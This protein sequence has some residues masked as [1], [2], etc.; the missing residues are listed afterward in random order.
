[1]TTREEKLERVNCPVCGREISLFALPEHVKACRK[2]CAA[3]GL[4]FCRTHL[5]AHARTPLCD[6]WVAR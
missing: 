3:E 1:M 5:W 2:A 6:A 4:G